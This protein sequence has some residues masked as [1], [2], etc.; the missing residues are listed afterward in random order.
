MPLFGRKK[1][2]PQKVTPVKPV[3]QKEPEEKPS[4]I[5]EMLKMN[6]QKPPAPEKREIPMPPM[7]V[8]IPEPVEE[9]P[10]EAK[11]E[12]SQFAPLFIKLDRYKN[13]LR[14]MAELKMI[15]VTIK[16]TLAMITEMD[17]LKADSMKMIQDAVA[18]IDKKLVTLDQEFLKPSGYHDMIP[19]Q[20]ARQDL[21]DELDALR[22]QIEALK[23]E[24]EET[25]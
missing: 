3:E 22:N 8:K 5:V 13:I 17:K 14:Q 19:Q 18:R 24:M 15:V 12:T 20:M 23:F 25:A 10:V 21:Q 2:E 1:E 4:E 7:A 16:N 11:K 6:L 9:E